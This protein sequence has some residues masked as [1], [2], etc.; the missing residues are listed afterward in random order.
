M[1]RGLCWLCCE[2]GFHLRALRELCCPACDV[3]LRG[4]VGLFG[5]C[6]RGLL[7][8]EVLGDFLE[9]REIL[10]LVAALCGERLGFFGAAF[11]FP[12]RRCELC[13]RG[14]LLLCGLWRVRLLHRGARLLHF[15]GRI[16]QRIRGLRHLGDLLR[17]RVRLSDEFALLILEPAELCLFLAL[18]GVEACTDFR[19]R[20]QRAGGLVAQALRQAVHAV[21]RRDFFREP[22]V[23]I[24]GLF[25]LRARIAHLPLLGDDLGE[26]ALRLAQRLGPLLARRDLARDFAQLVARRLFIS[27]GLEKLRG[28][29]RFHRLFRGGLRLPD[30][31]RGGLERFRRRCVLGICSE[32]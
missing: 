16:F 13:D 19:I 28:L 27:G 24:R 20:A 3:L 9:L 25:L 30:L 8:R 5:L 17:E 18:L 29:Q 2:R 26:F 22:L 11:Q 7:L 6:D 15:S 23:E 14:V 21:I 31:F 4:G 10:R 32:P 1:R 12:V